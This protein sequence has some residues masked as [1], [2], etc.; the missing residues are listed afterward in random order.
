MLGSFEASAVHSQASSGPNACSNEISGRFAI[1]SAGI[2]VWLGI[3]LGSLWDLHQR[4]APFP[5]PTHTMQK[6]AVAIWT[7]GNFN[8]V[9]R[10]FYESHVAKCSSTRMRAAWKAAN[11]NPN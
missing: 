6:L 1:D 7:M 8:N 11:M 2:M 4:D 9:W 3:C 10:R 5:L